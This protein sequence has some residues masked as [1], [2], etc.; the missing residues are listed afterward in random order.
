MSAEILA[1]IQFAVTAGFHFIFPPMSIGLGLLLVIMEGLYLKTK[2]PLYHKMTRF[3]VLVF[4]LTF[5]VGVATGIPMEFQFGT[6]WSR[7]SRY[8][9]DIFGSA[10]AAEG[11]FAFF[12]ESGFLAILVF[13]WN[14]VSPKM[15]FFS[16]CMVFM[17]SIFSA[18]WIL[19]ANSWQQTPAGFRL[20][21]TATGEVARITDFWAMV[22]NPSTVDRFT[23][24]VLASFLTGAFFAISV[25]AYYMLK[26]QHLDFARRSLK[27]ALSVALVAS[28]AQILVGHASTQHLVK[29]QPEKFATIEGHY[30]S[31][32]PVDL[33]I[34][35]SYNPQT[36]ET[37]G[38][39]IPNMGSVLIDGNPDTKVQGLDSFAKEDLPPVA[40]VFQSFRIMVGIGTFLLLLSL[41]GTISVFR[42]TLENKPTLLKVMIVSAVLPHIANLLGWMVA[43]VGRQPWSVYRLLRTS[44]S[45]SKVVSAGQIAGSLTMFI[46]LYILLGFLFFYLLDK[47]IKAGPDADYD[48]PEPLESQ[49]LKLFGAKVN[50]PESTEAKS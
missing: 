38:I 39:K 23:H 32:K 25:A 37:T 31:T 9:G 41:V 12:L 22:F 15:H 46:F 49:K 11:V 34:L 45:T 17:G 20:E 30:D 26:K 8:V 1:R 40:P 47:R 19:V 27:I 24:T 2:D 43:E 44:E 42:G 50:T 29:N 16:T 5:A 28:V 14:K 35:G 10:L 13:G 21:Q 3:W 6:N 7:Y 33:T 36:N 48:E 18:V 4:A